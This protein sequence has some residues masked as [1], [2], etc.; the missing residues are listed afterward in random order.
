[1]L[2]KLELIAAACENM[3]IGI[4][5][6]LPWR[7]KTEMEYFTRMTTKTKDNNKKNVVLMG[8]RTWDCLPKKYKPL[9]D[10]INIV[11]T[12]QSVDYGDKAIVCESM[13]DAL[14]TIADMKSKVEKVWVIGGSRVYKEAMESPYF[15]RLYLTRVRK[16]FECDTFFPPI[17]DNFVLIQDPAVPQDVQEENGIEFVYEVYEKR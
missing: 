10:R 15:N 13:L 12:S 3:G 14:E 11:L 4:K 5:G 7:L 6:N 1:M 17:P 9:K 2:P 16:N 8:R